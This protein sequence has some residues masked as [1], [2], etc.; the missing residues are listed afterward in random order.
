MGSTAVLGF[1]GLSLARG[2]KERSW[3]GLEP[4]EYAIV[5][6]ADAAAALLVGGRMAAAAAEERFDGVKHSSAFPAGAA[7]FAL[8][9]AGL[10]ASQIDLVAHSFSFGPERDFYV[11]Q[12]DYYRGLYETALDPEV[13][14]A[15]AEQHLG[16][17]LTGRFRPVAH[18][19]A[20]AAS[21]Y[22]PSGYRDALVLV[23]DGLG[24]R[25]SA[26]VFAA[27][28]SG[29]EPL[30]EV[31]AHSSLGLLYGLF[32]LYLGFAFGD[33]EYKVMGL[34]PHGDATRYVETILRDWV[35]LDSGGRYF[36]PLLLEN[37]SDL[38]KETYGAALA[39]IEREF[40]PR[41]D[42]DEPIEQRHKDIAAALQ[43]V[44]QRAQLHQ[45][46]H[47]RR[48]TGLARLCLA[49]GVA[50][51]CAANGVL[52]RSGLF[53]DIY[54]Q[55]ASGDDGAALGAAYV[56]AVESGERPEPVTGTAFGPAYGPQAYEQAVAAE[57]G[58]DI[59]RAADDA[60][61]AGLTARLIADGRIVGWFQGAMEFGPRAL[62]HRSILAD[63]RVVGMRERI[64]AL[65]KKRESFRPFAPAVTDEATA[66]L[67]EIEPEDVHRF[68]EMLFVGYVRP[69][70]AEQLPAITH[71][72]GSARVQSVS[73]RTSPLFWSLIEEFGGLT[74]LPV[75]LNTSFNVAG[76]P[77]VRTPDEA[78]RTFLA[79]G[80]DALVLGRLVITRAATEHRAAS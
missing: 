4:R 8:E 59:R 28:T 35:H 13:N 61:L 74:G 65:V 58:L 68:A 76:Q 41:R 32:T 11:G 80:L 15:V 24:E 79:A 12:S 18:H 39:R 47:Y 36:V 60:E 30:A 17:D 56:A 9:T 31:P 10:K 21:A 16:I 69:E 46:S 6:G 26:T 42:P 57:P 67:F 64:N 19:V 33:G 49:G 45:L 2:F 77:I 75:V 54:V 48:E 20:H 78:V 3:P 62:G 1:S 14:R 53:E 51:N 72:D 34:A 55:P 22:Y 70:Y 25:Q 23:S 43:A 63:P 52:L 66:T 50:L 38:D 29:L 73:R 37:V 40:G 5:Q 7:Q 44:L 71:V 27:G